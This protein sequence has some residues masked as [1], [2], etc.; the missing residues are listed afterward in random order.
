VVIAKFF[1]TK[2]HKNKVRETK[3]KNW[4]I[5][6]SKLHIQESQKVHHM[7]TS[8]VYNQIYIYIYIYM[9]V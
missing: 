3:T 1:G 9:K 7:G 4:Y 2:S 5:Y 6:M 8:T